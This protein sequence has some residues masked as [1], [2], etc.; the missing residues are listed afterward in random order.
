MQGKARKHPPVGNVGCRRRSA[1]AS[2]RSQSG[3]EKLAAERNSAGDTSEGNED[4]FG[5]G[6]LDAHSTPEACGDGQ[7]APGRSR[8]DTR[9]EGMRGES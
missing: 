5:V 6:S 3:G 2:T 1:E 9:R 8:D 4:C 7:G